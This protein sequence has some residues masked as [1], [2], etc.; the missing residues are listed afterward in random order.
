VK[1]ECCTARH[2][3]HKRY[4]HSRMTLFES[5]LLHRLSWPSFSD[6]FNSL[7]VSTG[8][9]PWLDQFRCCTKPFQFSSCIPT[10]SENKPLPAPRI[11]GLSLASQL[12][13]SFRLLKL[14]YNMP[15]S[16][17]RALFEVAEINKWPPTATTS[18]QA[19]YCRRTDDYNKL[20]VKR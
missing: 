3:N 15:S 19:T 13:E 8:V 6:C 14:N 18:A 11:I 1:S 4:F 17:H 9:V 20:R 7:Q 5:Q 16:Y 10:S 2:F 12:E